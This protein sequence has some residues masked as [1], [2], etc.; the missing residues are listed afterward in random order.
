MWFAFNDENKNVGNILLL[1]QIAID[2][3]KLLSKMKNE[4]YVL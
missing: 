4:E 2:H 1:R 3:W